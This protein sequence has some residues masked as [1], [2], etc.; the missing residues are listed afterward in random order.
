[1]AFAFPHPWHDLPVIEA[2]DQL[3]LHPHFAAQPFDD[4]DDIRVLA[5]R[6]H[7]IDQ[8]NSAALGFNFRFK[9]QRLAPIPAASCFNFLV[10][11]KSPVPIFRVA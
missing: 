2:D 4:A 7:E 6:R 5:T 11:K 1:M 8:A 3:H 9:N 10:R